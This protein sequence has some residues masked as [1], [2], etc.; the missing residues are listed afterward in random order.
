MKILKRVLCISLSL[1]FVSQMITGCTFKKTDDTIYLTRGEF[2]AYFVYEYGLSSARYTS[3]E[4]QE[5]KDGSV[6]AEI[7]AEWNYLPKDSASKNLK[8]SVDKETVVTVCANATFELKEGD[9]AKIKDADLLDNPQLI[10][11]AYESGF[12]ELEN[13]YFNGAKYMSFADCEAIVENAKEYTANFHYEANTEITS[14]AEGVKEQDTSNYQDGDIVVE[15]FGDETE[16]RSESAAAADEETTKIEGQTTGNAIKNTKSAQPILTELK[17]SNNS[18]KTAPLATATNP[19]SR[20]EVDGFKASMSKKVFEENLG[21]PQIGTTV[22]LKKY[23]PIFIS[24]IRKSECE[25]MG[26]LTEKKENGEIYTCTF[27]YPDFE[28]A[29]QDKNVERAN[30]SL[31]GVESFVKLETKVAGW[32]LNFSYTGSSVKIDASKPFSVYK[33]SGNKADWRKQKVTVNAKAGFEMSNFNLDINNIKSFASN[34]GSG[35]IKI[36]CDTTSS[37]SFSSSLRYTPDN[38]RNG[39]F[40]SN[41]N[42]S[43]WTDNDAKGAKRIKVAKFTPS[44]YGVVGIEVNI[45]ILL[46]FDGSISFVSSVDGGGVQFTANDGKISKTN[47]GKKE[48]ETKINA[49]VHLRCGLDVSLKIFTFINVIKYDVGID[50]D[51]CAIVNLYYEKQLSKGGVFADNEGLNEYSAADDKFEYCIGILVTVT[52]TGKLQESGVKMILDCIS[53]GDSLNFEKE[54]CSFGFHFE[55]GN[56]VDKCT[57]GSEMEDELKKNHNDEIELEEYKVVLETYTCTVISLTSIPSE[58][59][60]LL[61]SKNSITVSSNDTD[62]CNVSYNKKTKQILVEAVAPGSTEIVIK[63]K[64]GA[65]WWISTCEQKVSVTVTPN[66]YI[67]GMSRQNGKTHTRSR[68]SIMDLTVI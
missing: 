8:K 51:L 19:F 43:R 18:F 22:V 36:T 35:Y 59:M 40:P 65:L 50:V 29:A 44:L 42:N 52:L 62:V 6:E 7:I 9:P 53:K 55:D 54:L 25:I 38:N 21:N 48:N 20:L 11:N 27:K 63:A 49:N 60:N 17:T 47:L 26:I 33:E 2:F 16:E 46:K 64:K 30:G 13:G 32:T 39:K 3:K 15:F 5:C 24:D 67:D 37:A 56:F 1:L 57:R 66:S 58:T 4:I 10:A 68:Q 23:N 34:K 14:T 41:W 61:D 31:F 28:K 12:F 45:Y